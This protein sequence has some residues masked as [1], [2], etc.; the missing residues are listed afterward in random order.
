MR[1]A[2]SRATPRATCPSRSPG[3]WWC[4]SS[5]IG[6]SVR[7]V[8]VRVLLWLALFALAAPVASAA[9]AL[10]S[11]Q[12]LA[13]E[14]VEQLSPRL[15]D[16]SLRSSVVDGPLHVRVLLPAGYDDQP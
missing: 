4:S 15:L 6:A 10:R 14:K 12:G 16:V 9:P 8:I 7:S 13:V 11:G 5:G 2:S 1:C 3:G